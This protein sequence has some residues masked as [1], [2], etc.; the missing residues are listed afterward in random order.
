MKLVRSIAF[1]LS[2]AGVSV[3]A[4]ACGGTVES[5]Q[6][7]ASAAT[8]A[9]IG[10]NTHGVVRLVG[11]ALG[12]VP[13]RADQRAEIEK[14][15]AEAEARHAPMSD[16][17]KELMTTLAD[18]I[19]AGAID[20][21][22]L[23]PKIDKV[24]TDFEKIRADDRAALT[25]LHGLLDAEQRSAFVDALEKQLKAKHGE[26]AEHVKGGF[27]KLKQLA[28]DLKLTD[29]QRSQIRDVMR[30]ARKEGHDAKDGANA[31][32]WK[33]R[34]RGER[35]ASHSEWKR[36]GP[37]HGDGPHAGKRSLEAF[38][39][40]TFDLDKVAPPHDAK[41][42]ARFGVDR[43]SGFAEKVL[44]IL[45]PEQRKIAADKVRAMAAS[46]DATLL[47]R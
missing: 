47:G 20:R 39:A 37:R 18:Q 25:K 31:E 29:D 38:R 35:G 10:T 44:P 30:E 41:A 24:T 26:R 33:H 12:E 27:G 5:P 7:S 2:V 46:G 13:L 21:T 15:A 28:D 6:T 4:V 43:L 45:T 17:R 23:Q 32:G 8:K 42:T 14:L 34:A 19:E 40:D 22:A 3:F 36:G 16:A 11:D 9:P 1:S